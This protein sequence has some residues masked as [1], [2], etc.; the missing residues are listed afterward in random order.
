MA[1][2]KPAPSPAPSKPSPSKPE[3]SSPPQPQLTTAAGG[4]AQGSVQRTED[5]HVHAEASDGYQ[6]SASA[7]H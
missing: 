4:N 3:P 5:R 2:T 1:D 7:S 6:A